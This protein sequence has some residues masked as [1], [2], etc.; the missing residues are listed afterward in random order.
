MEK[1][2]AMDDV[3]QVRHSRQREALYA[4]LQD[5]CDHPTAETLYQELK[6]DFPNISLAT[7]YRNLRQLE[8]WGEVASITTGAAMRFDY[9]TRPHSH[10]F[11]EVCGAVMDL[12]DD[13]A[14]IVALGQEKF[15]GKIVGCY[16]HYYGLCPDCYKMKER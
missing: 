2:E 6:E 3:R 16:S 11:C 1:G 14:M 8:S 15:P 9:D 12:E 13:N 10:F 4:R 5:R 7:V